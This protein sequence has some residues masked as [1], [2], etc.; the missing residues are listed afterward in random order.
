[1]PTQNLQPTASTNVE[2]ERVGDVVSILHAYNRYFS[3]LQFTWSIL[4]IYISKSNESLL[5]DALVILRRVS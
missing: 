5:C 2:K 3:I 1:M 4:V